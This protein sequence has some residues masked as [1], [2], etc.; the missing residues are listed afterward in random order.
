[1][2]QTITSLPAG[3]TCRFYASQTLKLPCISSHMEL[4][5]PVNSLLK[6]AAIFAINNRTCYKQWIR[7]CAQSFD[8]FTYPRQFLLPPTG[9]LSR[10]PTLRTC[11]CR[12]RVLGTHRGDCHIHRLGLLSPARDCKSMNMFSNP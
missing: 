8:L 2:A 6:Q 12:Q 11:T 5:N 1:M 3:S 10:R 4:G 9:Q 7:K